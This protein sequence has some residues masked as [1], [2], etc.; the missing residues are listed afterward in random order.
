[1]TILYTLNIFKKYIFA[2]KKLNLIFKEAVIVLNNLDCS[3]ISFSG[4]KKLNRS[5]LLKENI[6]YLL[7]SLKSK[8]QENEDK[9]R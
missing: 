6:T 3:T 7:N 5:Q 4:S 9:K 8:I 1:M 2:E